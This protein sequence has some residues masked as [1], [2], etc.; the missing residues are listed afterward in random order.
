MREVPLS[1]TEYNFVLKA[2][3]ENLRLDK[4]QVYDVRDTK[5]EFFQTRG[6]CIA[7]LGDTKV[8]AQCSAEL[9]KPKDTRPNEGALRINLELSPMAAQH[10]EPNKQTDFGVELNRLLEKNIKQSQCLDLE[11]LCIRA[12]EKVWQV[13]VDLNA[14]N[15]D[16]NILDC[17]NFA[18]ICALSHYR[19]PEVEV[20]GDQIRIF[21]SEERSPMPLSILHIPLTTTF[22]FFD[23]G[24][25]LLVDP[26]DIEERCMDGKLVIGMNRHQEICTM[27]LSGNILLLK[28]QIKRC[29]NI[30]GS[31][32]TQLTE[33]IQ[34]EVAKTNINKY[35][36]RCILKGEEAVMKFE[37]K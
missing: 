35:K 21:T 28:D 22:A 36:K 14:L 12:G 26:T 10:F 29:V 16:G 31:K 11:S 24:K 15:H 3:S 32:V 6:G 20:V 30:A 23:Q 2:L 37:N 7:S 33:Y 27:Q 1:L 4:R 25:Y 8:S 18:V 5:V 34:A 19:I 13:R 9:V 17:A